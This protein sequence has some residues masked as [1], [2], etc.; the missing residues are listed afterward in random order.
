M[1]RLDEELAAIAGDPEGALASLS[2]LALRQGRVV[3]VQ[4]FGRRFIDAQDPQGD[5]AARADTLYRIASISKLVTTL[6]VMKLVEAGRLS[7]DGDASEWLGWRLRNPRFPDV[8][9]TPRMMLSHTSSIRDDGGYNWPEPVK[10]RDALAANTAM[11]ATQAPPGAWF[12]YAN[13]PWGLLG[14]II[15][16]ASGERFDRFMRREVLA[17]L[18]MDATYNPADLGDKAGERIATLYRKRTGPE[19]RETWDPE[20]PWNAQV[21]DYSRGPPVARASDAYEIGTNGTLFGP[22]GGLRASASDL[23]RVARMLLGRGEIEGQRILQPATVAQMLATQWRFDG[24]NGESDYAVTRRRFNAWG[25]GNQHFLDVSG[26]AHGDRL[27]EGGG[28]RAVGHLGDAYGLTSALVFDP[29]SGD[30]MVFLTGGS[31]F[32]PYA[33]PGHWSALSR[34]EERILTALWRRGVRGIDP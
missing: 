5:R 32:D 19:G 4:Q 16:R 6:G 34:Y 25:L 30:G 3:H 13:L 1:I 7:L 2:V 10:L 31:A 29:G 33:R 14:T 15:E 9:V 17:P 18:G 26:P 21:D 11:W 24:H 20:G 23:G 22:Q 28:F 27:V 8:P 12:E